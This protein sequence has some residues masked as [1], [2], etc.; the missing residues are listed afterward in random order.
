[1]V[2]R[3]AALSHLQSSRSWSRT[4]RSFWVFFPA[5]VLPVCVASRVVVTTCRFYRVSDRGDLRETSQQRQ[6]ACRA[7]ETG[8]YLSTNIMESSTLADLTGAIGGTASWARR[9]IKAL[10]GPFSTH[11]DARA[12]T[13]KSCVFGQLSN[14]LWQ[15]KVFQGPL[16]VVSGHPP[17]C[18]VWAWPIEQILLKAR[19][20]PTCMGNASG[21][22]TYGPATEQAACSVPSDKEGQRSPFTS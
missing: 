20:D 2:F 4:P 11:P 19:Y 21:H 15:P 9:P 1:M 3:T 12:P 10:Y 22:R 18:S 17:A 14:T 8:R 13:F 5:Q 7:E 6:G 16:R